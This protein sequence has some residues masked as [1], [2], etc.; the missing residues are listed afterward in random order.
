MFGRMTLKGLCANYFKK[1]GGERL[2]KFAQ[3]SN[4]QKIWQGGG[5]LNTE[6]L[7]TDLKPPRDLAR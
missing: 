7:H 3:T 2:T 4:L 6:G 5:H 1:I